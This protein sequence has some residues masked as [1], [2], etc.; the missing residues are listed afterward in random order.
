MV[1]DVK[2]I[3]AQV[4]LVVQKPASEYKQRQCWPF[5]SLG[6]LLAKS[7]IYLG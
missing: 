2:I 4:C 3:L 7:H 5:G 1:T 6:L